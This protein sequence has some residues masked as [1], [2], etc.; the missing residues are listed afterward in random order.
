MI[1]L[2]FYSFLLVDTF[3]LLQSLLLLICLFSEWFSLHVKKENR[4][5]SYLTPQ[6]LIIYMEISSICLTETSVQI[7][8][9]I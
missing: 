1:E 7:V 2:K 6:F 3:F 9:F 8:I 5:L 4:S